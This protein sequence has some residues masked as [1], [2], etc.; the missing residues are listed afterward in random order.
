MTAR[1]QG[2]RNNQT[3]KM[4]KIQIIWLN[5]LMWPCYMAWLEGKEFEKWW[6]SLKNNY[7]RNSSLCHVLIILNYRCQVFSWFLGQWT[8]VFWINDSFFPTFAEKHSRV[9]FMNK[10]LLFPYL[11]GTN[12]REFSPSCNFLI[13]SQNSLLFVM[14][15]SESANPLSYDNFTRL[16]MEK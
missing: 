4:E 2:L 13:L 11:R 9:A 5:P 16:E 3:M 7:H 10:W 1:Y 8:V 12:L 14:W 15:Q 6:K